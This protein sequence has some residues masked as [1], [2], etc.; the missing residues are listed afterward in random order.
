V[1]HTYLVDVGTAIDIPLMDASKLYE[2]CILEPPYPKIRYFEFEI[3]EQRDGKTKTALF[4]NIVPVKAKQKPDWHI[5]IFR[6][7]RG[8]WTITERIHFPTETGEAQWLYID[9]FNILFLSS[10]GRY[11]LDLLTTMITGKLNAI[12]QSYNSGNRVLSEFEKQLACRTAIKT[13]FSEGIDGAFHDAAIYQD[14]ELT[15]PSKLQEDS[16]LLSGAEISSHHGRAR[17]IP[18]KAADLHMNINEIEDLN[19]LSWLGE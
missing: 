9:D 2:D 4:L 7:R 18:K 6:I 14:Y 3:D 17:V 5:L 13:L 1:H 15:E 10:G 16:A 19:D 12:A 11:D 8:S